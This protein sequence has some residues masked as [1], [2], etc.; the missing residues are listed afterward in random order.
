MALCSTFPNNG[1]PG[2]LA[3]GGAPMVGADQRGRT[4]LDQSDRTGS[5]LVSRLEDHI[6][7]IPEQET[8][9]YLTTWCELMW[10]VTV[11]MRIT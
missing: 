3:L 2:W 8:D 10:K 4:G 6:Q 9:T 7:V 5:G 11:A 1:F